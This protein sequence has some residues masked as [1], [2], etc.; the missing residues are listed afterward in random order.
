MASVAG[1]SEC[2]AQNRLGTQAIDIDAAS[3]DDLWDDVERLRLATGFE[4]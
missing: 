1:G 3:P 4:T 2:R